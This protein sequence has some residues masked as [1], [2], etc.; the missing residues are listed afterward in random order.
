VG[1]AKKRHR[2][3]YTHLTAAVVFPG[4]VALCWWQ[5]SRALSG[6]TLSWAYVFEWPIFG[7]YAVFM[8][9][10]LIHDPPAGRAA[11]GGDQTQQEGATGPAGADQRRETRLRHGGPGQSDAGQEKETREDEEMASYNSYLEA[12]QASDKPKRQ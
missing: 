12:L 10:K 3:L 9:W 4:C 8:W 2:N 7:G 11:S 1:H 5:V 6:N